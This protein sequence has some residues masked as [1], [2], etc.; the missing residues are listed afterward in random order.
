MIE[1]VESPVLT[2]LDAMDSIVLC[3]C[4]ACG[5]IQL[6]CRMIC[7]PHFPLQLPSYEPLSWLDQG[8]MSDQTSGGL[9]FLH[10]E[11]LQVV[12]HQVHCVWVDD[13]L[14]K[15]IDDHSSAPTKVEP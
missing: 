1:P 12:V 10:R 2:E 3:T 14:T 8:Y 5:T 11:Y 6:P 15:H 7:L 4:D 9:L 13:L